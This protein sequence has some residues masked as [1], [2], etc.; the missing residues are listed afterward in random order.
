M[1]ATDPAPVDVRAGWPAVRRL[2]LDLAGAGAVIG[3]VVGA[4]AWGRPGIVG[5]F[6]GAALGAGV[7]ALAGPRRLTLHIDADGVRIGRLFERETVPWA[8][9][10]ALGIEDAWSGRRGRSTALG[11]CRRG[12]EWPRRVP[13]LTVH[14]A[15]FRLGGAAPDAV[16]APQRAAILELVAPWA[17]ARSVPLVAGGVEDWWDRHRV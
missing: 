3:A 5:L 15:G 10:V 17:E 6:A 14:A 1:D 4:L 2:V 9:V 12:A 16:L 13:A 11:V 7:A 8:E